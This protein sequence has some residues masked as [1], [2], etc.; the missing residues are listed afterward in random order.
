MKVGNTIARTVIALAQAS[1][2]LGLSPAVALAQDSFSQS[3]LTRIE[4]A[5]NTI[6]G[7][8][9]RSDLT[10]EAR[11]RVLETN[12]FGDYKKSGS[13]SSRLKAVDEMISKTPSQEGLLLPPIAPTYDNGHTNI[14][15]A[16]EIAPMPEVTESAAD[17]GSRLLKQAMDRYAAGD[18]VSAKRLFQE[19]T[20]VDSNSEDAYF[21]LGVIAESEGNKK[22]ALDYYRRA[23]QINPSD[24]ELRQTVDTL[25]RQIGDEDREA[26]QIALAKQ[27]EARKLKEK[28]DLDTMRKTVADASN[29]YK[30][31]RYDQ[32]VRKLEAVAAK[33]PSEPDIQYALGQAQ[34]AKGDFRSAKVSFDRAYALNPSSTVYRGAVEEVNNQIASSG[35]TSAPAVADSTPAGQITPFTPTASNPNL[36]RESYSSYSQNS[37][38]ASLFAGSRVKRALMGSAA[39]AATGALVSATTKRSSVKSGAIQG[40]LMG[41]LLGYLSGQ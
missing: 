2:L 1:L 38:V 22:E 27:E 41:G 33:A 37:G 40:A 15:E 25:S 6:F 28:Q 14:T 35:Q 7:Q 29:D 10:G 3:D 32:A 12:L 18:M 24:A 36:G 9:D 31:G 11:L 4:K 34:R 39:G 21:N 26:R 16:P 17:P 20:R 19:V 23:F 5:E 13:I 30:A 8:G